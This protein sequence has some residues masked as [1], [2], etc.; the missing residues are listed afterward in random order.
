MER[1]WMGCYKSFLNHWLCEDK[2][3]S[4]FHCTS[5]RQLFRAKLALKWEL[6]SHPC[7][8]VPTR[9]C[10]D[11]KAAT[12][13]SCPLGQQIYAVPNQTS[14]K[15][16]SWPEW[17]REIKITMCILLLFRGS[18]PLQFKASAVISVHSK[19]FP[20]CFCPQMLWLGHNMLW[21]HIPKQ[22][23]GSSEGQPQ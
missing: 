13:N 23:Y 2:L 21:L 1:G 18:R 6:G 15:S 9:P 8:L 11:T 12:V 4:H 7:H 5:T 19:S 22:C 3:S 20:I 16:N 10:G 17:G 14:K